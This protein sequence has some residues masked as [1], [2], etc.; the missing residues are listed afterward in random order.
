MLEMR[1]LV[2]LLLFSLS[3]GCASGLYFDQIPHTAE[4]GVVV[5][6]TAIYDRDDPSTITLVMK[7]RNSAGPTESPA[8]IEIL[9]QRKAIATNIPFTF[10]P[11]TN[12]IFR[13]VAISPPFFGSQA[14]L[15]SDNLASSHN[16]TVLEAGGE[17]SFTL[18]STTV[19]PKTSSSQTVI[20]VSS[21]GAEP[22]PPTPIPGPSPPSESSSKTSE[23]SAPTIMI[24]GMATTTTSDHS[25]PTH[26]ESSPSTDTGTPNH[27]GTANK[28][29]KLA[30]V[31]GVLSAL[32]AIFAGMLLFVI[33]NRR[34]R[35]NAGATE[36][37]ISSFVDLEA[38]TEI[39]STEKP[40]VRTGTSRVAIVDSQ[41]S[42]GSL[43]NT[44]SL[45]VNLG[46]QTFRKSTHRQTF[47]RKP[48]MVATPYPALA[49]DHEHEPQQFTRDEQVA[50]ET[51]PDEDQDGDVVPVERTEHVRAINR[52]GTIT[53]RHADSGFRVSMV[54]LPD[55]EVIEL[56]PE[57][58]SK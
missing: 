3:L 21:T 12:G 9:T 7:E 6:A 16:F 23:L 20:M 51:S 37:I 55:R 46:G 48:T 17:G 10:K 14:G 18:S 24:A 13:I 44:S 15:D 35:K 11:E 28:P 22:T 47:L 45:D 25:A 4:V 38:S 54:G 36:G 32:V 39:S 52:R 8:I 27:A 50:S 31:G 29:N 49:R 30:I 58:S 42:L 33:W 5:S 34:Q 2:L 19:I 1:Y 43:P 56:P 53:V 26:S 57:Y 41:G 40:R